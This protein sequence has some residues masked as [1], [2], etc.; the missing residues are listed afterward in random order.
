[1]ASTT[2]TSIIPE[3]DAS[4]QVL[5]SILERLDEEP[6]KRVEPFITDIEEQRGKWLLGG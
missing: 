6:L 2:R 4:S 1:M 3:R 5:S